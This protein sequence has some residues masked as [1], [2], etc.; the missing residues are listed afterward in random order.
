MVRKLCCFRSWLVGAGLAW[1]GTLLAGEPFL[2]DPF[3]VDN[4]A[5]IPL[6]AQPVPPGTYINRF[7]QIQDTNAQ[8]DDFVIYKHMWF[9]GGKALGP[10]G[11]YQLDLISKRLPTVP[12]PV[13]IETSQNA[14]LD[15]A[16]RDAILAL[17]VQRGFEDP[18]RVIVAYPVAE[19]LYG[20]EAEQ[21]ATG[22]LRGGLAGTGGLGAGGLGGTGFGGVPALGGFPGGSGFGGG[23]GFRP[24]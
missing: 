16:R 22:Y 20:D 6:G 14:E 7:I 5:T 3:H 4:C 21:I 18:S 8:A 10:L 12:F 17:L 11:R 9:Q 1:P 23:L 13:V 2:L 15:E 24:F 19:G